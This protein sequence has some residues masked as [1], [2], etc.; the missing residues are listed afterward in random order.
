VK[1]M[2]HKEML[3]RE[4]YKIEKNQ[5]SVV[6]VAGETYTPPIPLLMGQVRE[7]DKWKWKGEMSLPESSTMR[8]KPSEADISVIT[9]KL[10]VIGGPFD[11]YFVSVKLKISDGS[12]NPSKRELRF[13]FVPSKGL[14]KREFDYSSLREPD[15]RGIDESTPIP[16]EINNQS[17]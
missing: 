15:R 17:Q 4:V 13:W 14:I 7:G 12:P 9:E 6:E 3:E 16:D 5:F 1:V 2:A 10:N 11:S 8:P